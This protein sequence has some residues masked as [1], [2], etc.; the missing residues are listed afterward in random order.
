MTDASDHR[1]A[2]EPC[3]V[4]R[5]GF[6]PLEQVRPPPLHYYYYYQYYYYYYEYEYG[7]WTDARAS[8]PLEQAAKLLDDL[9][10]NQVCTP[11]YY[12]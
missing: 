5:K 4:R 6:Y 10:P 12:Y 2:A 9:I 3:F 8:T 11:L 1:Y 7:Q